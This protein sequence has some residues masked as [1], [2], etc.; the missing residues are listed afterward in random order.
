MPPS[1][2]SGTPAAATPSSALLDRRDLRHADAGDDARRAD[3]AGA[4][5]DLDRVGA[6]VD[7]R[8]APRGGRD[9]AAD[10]LHLRIALLDPR[11]RDRARPANGRATVST[12]STSTPAATSASTRS[13]CRRRRRPRRRRASGRARPCR[14]CGCSV[15]LRM[16]LTVIRPRSSKRVV[17]DQHALEPVLVHQRLRASRGRCPRAR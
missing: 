12:T 1:A 4:D 16:S 2:I 9:V 15:D 3:R 13:R 6:V 8:R 11:A 14:R 5:A 7:Q 17:D 10:D